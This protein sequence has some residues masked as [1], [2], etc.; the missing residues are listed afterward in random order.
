MASAGEKTNKNAPTPSRQQRNKQDFGR[1]KNKSN[2]KNAD[3]WF[4]KES[5]AGGKNNTKT[6]GYCA[7]SPGS[8]QGGRILDKDGWAAPY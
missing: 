5:E 7:S 8:Y 3:F 6:T 1:R 2:Y 4:G